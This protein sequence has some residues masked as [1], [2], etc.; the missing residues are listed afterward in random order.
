MGSLEVVAIQDEEPRFEHWRI[1]GLVP[2][3]EGRAWPHVYEPQ[4]DESGPFQ[5]EL[6][7]VILSGQHG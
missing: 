3:L 1:L 5:R 7:L 6:A 2:A 4:E